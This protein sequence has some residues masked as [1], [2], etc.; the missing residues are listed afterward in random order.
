MADHYCLQ[1]GRVA[2]YANDAPGIQQ[3]QAFITNLESPAV[4]C[5]AS[6]GYEREMVLTL[7]ATGVRVSVVNPLRVREFAR[8]MGR[9]A[10][11]ESP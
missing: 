10:K 6:G 5:E 1:S 3:L 4:V 11:T 9:L 2:Q 7:S 8:T